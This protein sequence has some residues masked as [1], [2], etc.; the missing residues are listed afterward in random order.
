MKEPR[1][2]EEYA[3]RKICSLERENRTVLADNEYYRNLA[4]SRLEKINSLISDL[5]FVFSFAKPTE[6]FNDAQIISFK[7][8][9]STH[10]EYDYKRLKELIE[11][12]TAEEIPF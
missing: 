6:D 11:D 2:F 3:V 12:Y 7:D 1:T 9:W 5:R 8:V 4:A 10:N